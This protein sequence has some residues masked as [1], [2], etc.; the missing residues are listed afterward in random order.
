MCS[1]AYGMLTAHCAEAVADRVA[2]MKRRA[3]SVDAEEL[4]AYEA[5]LLQG[6]TLAVSELKL[7]AGL[8]VIKIGEIDALTPSPPAPRPIAV[9]AIGDDDLELPEFLRR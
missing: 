8:K 6:W 3:P 1:I 5:G 9:H 2:E 4:A 7:H